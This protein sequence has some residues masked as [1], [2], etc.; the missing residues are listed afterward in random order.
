VKLGLISVEFAKV[1]EAK[2]GI[3]PEEKA[4]ILDLE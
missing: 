2:N 1:N 4:A 3:K